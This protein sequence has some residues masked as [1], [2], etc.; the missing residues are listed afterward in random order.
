[1]ASMAKNDYHDIAKQIMAED[2]QTGSYDDGPDLETEAIEF[3][4][5]GKG[6]IKQW[7]EMKG[8]DPKIFDWRSI[9]NKLVESNPNYLEGRGTTLQEAGAQQGISNS[10]DSEILQMMGNELDGRD[11]YEQD[12]DT[13]GGGL[14]GLWQR[15]KNDEQLAPEEYKMLVEDAQN[16]GSEVMEDSA[17]LK[18]DPQAF[19]DAMY[20]YSDED[21]VAYMDSLSPEELQQ[22]MAEIANSDGLG[23]VRSFMPKQ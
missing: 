6:T 2:T 10:T 22:L 7:A 23:R 17:R 3:V 19:I 11:P 18:S 14:E 8:I 1:M 15:F 4:T 12:M 21:E 13:Q 5:S 20:E 16:S 9:S